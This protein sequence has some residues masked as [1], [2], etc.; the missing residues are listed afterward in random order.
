MKNWLIFLLICA[1]V[2]DLQAQ[3]SLSGTVRDAET[4]GPVAGATVSLQHSF[5]STS[6]D[7]NG[8]FMIRS[9]PKGINTFRVSSLGYRDTTLT[10]ELNENTSQEIL[11]RKSVFV[12]E[13][14]I[15]SSVRASEKSAVAYTTLSAEELRRRNVGQDIP[16]L[17]NT[18]PSAVVTSDAGAGVGYTNIRIRGS[19]ITRINVTVNG[20]PINDA[21]SHGVW[22]VNMPDIASSTE[23]LQIQRGVGTSAN[24]AAAFGATMNLQTTK[25]NSEPYGEVANA[26]GS[27]NTRKHTLSFGTGL[28][29]DKFT[30]DGRLSQIASDGY[31]DRASSDLRSFFVSG[32]YYGNKNL[33]RIN[34]FS[35][36]EKTYQAWNGVPEALLTTNRTYNAY[37]YENQT[38]NYKQD[39]YQLIYNQQL[40]SRWNLNTALH[41]TRGK[42]YY[43]QYKEDQKFKDYGLEDVVVNNQVVSTTDL[44]RQ[45]WL[46]NDFYGGVWSLNYAGD[47]TFSTTLGG[48]W[49]LY[50]GNHFGEVVWAEYAATAGTKHRYYFNNAVKTDFNIYS[51]TIINLSKHFS[52]A[53]DLQY[54]RIRY[55][56][57]GY[58]VDLNNVE[59][60]VTLNFF[61]PKIGLTYNDL[62]GNTAYVFFGIGHKEPNRDD[63]T[64]SSSNDRPRP[65]KL[66]DL[67]FGYKRKR[68]IYSAGVNF[69]YMNYKD[70]LVLTGEINQVGAYNR[71]NIARSFRAGAETEFS[72]Q[73]NKNLFFNTNF[74]YSINKIQDF[75]EFI[76]NY[77]NNTQVVNEYKNTDIA[78]SPSLVA[79]ASLRYCLFG[80]TEAE[81]IQKYV[82]RQFLDNTS[83]AARALQPFWTTDVR[84]AY[85]PKMKFLERLDFTLQVNNIFNHLYEPNGYTFSHI[86]G[87]ELITENYYFP[88][89]GINFSAGLAIRF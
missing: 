66:R 76:D 55:S 86:S 83:N 67:E 58:D 63:Y 7:K 89:A 74:T 59:Q 44:V 26:F 77:D 82:S 68:K 20:I 49:N 14:V 80:N 42:G 13:E 56:F 39:H 3:A 22:W 19:D 46:D 5:L 34:V 32:G 69:Y 11:L 6:A 35:G 48:S 12:N 75:K 8:I 79:S 27:F 38:D 84:L 18:T 71:T 30:F 61:N 53:P 29:K 65:E 50:D 25:L 72:L 54:R 1:S 47:G 4:G 15:I 87:G 51:K 52:I 33:I 21:E 10:L 81:L 60:T 64:Q 17:L 31:I 9:L 85:S 88:Q 2:V 16:F 43:E 37:T 41:F 62:G 73:L 23:S 40:G 28:L 45:L 36:K 70:Q 57:L 24:G 78:F